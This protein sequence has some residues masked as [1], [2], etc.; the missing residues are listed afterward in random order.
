MCL[1]RPNGGRVAGRW[2]LKLRSVL[3]RTWLE[4]S[5]GTDKGLIFLFIHLFIWS[6][7]FQRLLKEMEELLGC[8]RS[9]LL[10]LSSDVELSKQAQ[11]LCSSLWAKGVKVDEDMLKVCLSFL[12]LYEL[13]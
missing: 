5:S 13:V 12:F 7:I 2:T 3:K 9:L 10:P 11:H 1:R 8:W 4:E 6:T